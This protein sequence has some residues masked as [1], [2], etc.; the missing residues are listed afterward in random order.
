[1]IVSP[2]LIVT[3]KEGIIIHLELF[4]TTLL[5]CSPFLCSSGS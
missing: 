4:Y 5:C 1:M 3:D 2:D